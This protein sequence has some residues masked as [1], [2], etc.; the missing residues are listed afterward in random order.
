MT[1]LRCLGLLALLHVATAHTVKYFVYAEEDFLINR[2]C[3]IDLR[4]RYD[5]Q[6]SLAA[7]WLRDLKNSSTAGQ[8]VRCFIVKC[9]PA[10]LTPGQARGG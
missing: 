2:C 10:Q 8:L 1:N 6:Y 9:P 3:S 7:L 5:S 4:G